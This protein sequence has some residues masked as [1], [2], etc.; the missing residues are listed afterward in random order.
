MGFP[1]RSNSLFRYACAAW[2][3][4]LDVSQ[5]NCASATHTLLISLQGLMWFG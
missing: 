2:G 1:N 5:S 4:Y 3:T